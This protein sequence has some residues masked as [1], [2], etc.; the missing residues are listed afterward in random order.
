MSRERVFETSKTVPE[1][2]VSL[3]GTRQFFG[4][5]SGM[6]RLFSRASVS[7]AEQHLD[8]QRDA[9]KQQAAS[10]F[11]RAPLE[12]SSTSG[13]SWPRCWQC[14]GQATPWS[15]GGSTGWGARSGT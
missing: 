15:S 6:A 13:P 9:L 8:L 12:G 10:G 7:T 3:V 4:T 5:V 1:I 2:N 11:S 14:S